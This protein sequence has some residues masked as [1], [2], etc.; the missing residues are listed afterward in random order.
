MIFQNPFKSPRASRHNL[1][2]EIHPRYTAASRVIISIN[3]W[4]KTTCSN[5]GQKHLVWGSQFITSELTMPKLTFRRKFYW[6]MPYFSAFYHSKLRR[7]NI[8]FFIEWVT[9]LCRK[10]RLN[11]KKL[12]D[13]TSVHIIFA[14]LS[15][16]S[17]KSAS[18]GIISITN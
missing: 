12:H 16:Y 9:Y 14:F 17:S 10:T 8:H 6:K 18:K 15:F 1:C 4:S 3:K 5:E 13:L 11:H 2:I 7:K